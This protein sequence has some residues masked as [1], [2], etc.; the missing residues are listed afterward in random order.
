VIDQAVLDILEPLVKEF[1][2]CKLTAYQDDDGVWTIGWGHTGD[3]VVEGLVWTQEQADTALA[4][5]LLFHYQETLA[6][7]PALQTYS[8]SRQAALV[9][10]VYNLGSGRYRSST[11]RSA[12]LVGAWVSVKAQLA[13]WVHSGGHIDPGL[14]RRRDAEIALIDS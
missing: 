7:T 5:D 12:V 3:E 11:L 2:G 10:F 4:A 1:E 9:D 6:L 13:L 8:P 14:V